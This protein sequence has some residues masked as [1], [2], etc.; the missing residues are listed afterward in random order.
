MTPTGNSL[1]I[2]IQELTCG[3]SYQTKK[4]EDFL[5]KRSTLNGNVTKPWK[6]FQTNTEHL[7]IFLGILI[8]M[9]LIPL[10]ASSDY[11]RQKSSTFGI[12]SVWRFVSRDQFQN[13]LRFLHL[14]EWNGFVNPNL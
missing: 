13:H 3:H 14:P 7:Y 5:E 6:D 11:F 9:G 1:A 10:R 12:P 2:L 8:R 4:K